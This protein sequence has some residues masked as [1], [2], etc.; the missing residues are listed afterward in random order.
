MVVTL[1]DRP[2]S[3]SDQ[4]TGKIEGNVLIT[5]NEEISRISF[6]Q[7]LFYIAVEDRMAVIHLI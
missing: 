7:Y 1:L 3:G 6:G 5:I 2:I 4:R